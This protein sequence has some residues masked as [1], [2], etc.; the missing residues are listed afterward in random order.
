M[1]AA[2]TAGGFAV[3][4]IAFMQ[5]SLGELRQAHSSH[6]H[7]TRNI[8]GTALKIG[9]RSAVNGA[10]WAKQIF[11]NYVDSCVS[12]FSASSLGLPQSTNQAAAAHPATP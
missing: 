8:H 3:C 12:D 2:G 1:S 9:R 7:H 11:N 4:L 10:A 5:I 6:S